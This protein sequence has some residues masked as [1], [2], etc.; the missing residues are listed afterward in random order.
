MAVELLRTSE[1]ILVSDVAADRLYRQLW[2]SLVTVSLLLALVVAW[3]ELP[4]PLREEEEALPPQLARI[5]LE[6]REIPPPPPKPE[7]KPEPEKPKPEPKPGP[8]PEVKPEPKPQ[9]VSRQPQPVVNQ[10]REQARQRAAS[11]GVMAA[12]DDLAA[13]R[14]LADS[15]LG[16]GPLTDDASAVVSDAPQVDRALLTA[17]VAAGSGGINSAAVSRTTGGASVAGRS[18]SS[19]QGSRAEQGRQ[20]QATS[21]SSGGGNGGGRSEEEVRLVLE[22]AKASLYT[23]Y[24]RELR[25]NPLLKG[26]VM[27]ELVIEP[28]GKVSSVKVVSSQLAAPELEKKLVARRKSLNFGSRDVASTTTKWAVAFLPQ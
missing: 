3:I 21:R 14:E 18:T 23:L 17:G 11:A 10:S 12:E 4:E 9:P 27:F 16:A 8:K 15:D 26:K 24:N 6:E 22:R 13:L 5:L 2:R 19:V 7:P 25:K 20:Q 28:S 1:P